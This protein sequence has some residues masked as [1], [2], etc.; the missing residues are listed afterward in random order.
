MSFILKK[1]QHM[2]NTRLPF[3]ETQ[4]MHLHTATDIYQCS[5]KAEKLL[6]WIKGMNKAGFSLRLLR[7]VY[8]SGHMDRLFGG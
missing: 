2:N 7:V 3:E 8:L 4:Y 1:A 6:K 5:V